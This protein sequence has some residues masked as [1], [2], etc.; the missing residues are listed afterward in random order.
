MYVLGTHFAQPPPQGSS[1]LQGKKTCESQIPHPLAPFVAEGSVIWKKIKLHF[2]AKKPWGLKR[3]V[4]FWK[5]RNQH[6]LRTLAV[7]QTSSYTII[8]KGSRQTSVYW[9]HVSVPPASWTCLEL[10]SIPDSPC[11]LPFLPAVPRQTCIT[12]FSWVSLAYSWAVSLC[13]HRKFFWYPLAIILSVSDI[14]HVS[15]SYPIQ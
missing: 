2:R 7:C 14:L 4:W 15:T 1:K 8:T 11:H 12:S 3:S 10:H 6:Q 5:C 13:F 9:Y